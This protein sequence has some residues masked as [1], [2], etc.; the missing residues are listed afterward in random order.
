MLLVSKPL[1]PTR[2]RRLRPR[3]RAF[4]CLVA[5]AAL[6]PAA[7]AAFGDEAE[8]G[9]E[10][11]LEALAA[12][13]EEL[14]RLAEGQQAEIDALKQR[15]DA[16]N[17]A[18][19]E[20]EER[21]RSLQAEVESPAPSLRP[22][23]PPP[24]AR[25]PLSKSPLLVSGEVGL[26]FFAGQNNAQFANEE[27]RIDDARLLFEA[28]LA[29]NAY[30]VSELELFRRETTDKGV[31]VGQLYVDFENVL[32]LS[33]HFRLANLRVGRFDTPF[34][35]EY[36]HRY[37]MANPLV[38]RS[39]TDFWG[40]DEGLALYGA[41]GP[42][43]YALAVQNGG[44]SPLRDFDGDK[45]I[46]LRMGYEPTRRL[47]LSGSVMRTGALDA[48]RDRGSEMWIGNVVFVPIGSEATSEFSA[49]LAQLDAIWSWNRGRIAAAAGKAWYED[50]DPLDPADANHRD[51]DFFQIEGRFDFAENYF[52]AARYSG[53]RVNGG[54][55]LAGNGDLGTF[56]FGDNLTEE[57]T[58]LSLGFGRWIGEDVVFKAEYS[59]EDGRLA[60]GAERTGTGQL[61]AEI[62]ARF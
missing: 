10:S 42:F 23:P 49:K 9:L 6:L 50:D 28:E 3:R 15:L 53:L 41:S 56:F 54:Y 7:G 5:L 1:P 51:F 39:V 19:R 59:F 38:S 58:R 14:R 40:I 13:N 2:E 21:L 8:T 30:F 52:A 18:E 61:S 12:Q 36:Q 17:Q 26:A 62:G 34:G 60:S 44:S 31:N 55:P 33:D 45:S 35:E 47:R 24:P 43:S 37:V 25:G 16:I 57:L 20:R 29:R 4:L 32:G 27:F 48:D 46:A 22:P 11:R